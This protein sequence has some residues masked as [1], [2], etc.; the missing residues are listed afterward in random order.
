MIEK[1]RADRSALS[2]EQIN[3]LCAEFLSVRHH[4]FDYMNELRKAGFNAFAPFED[5]VL[6]YAKSDEEVALHNRVIV[7]E[8]KMLLIGLPWR[9]VRL[10][11]TGPFYSE[12][13]ENLKARRDEEN[14]VP[15]RE[16]ESRYPGDR[17]VWRLEFEPCRR[18]MAY[19][20]ATNP[21]AFE[22]QWKAV[23][24][25]G[26][27]RV[28]EE[29]T[30]FA[31]RLSEAYDFTSGGRHGLFVAVMEQEAKNLGFFYD[32]ERS[33]PT[34]PIFSNS[35]TP[36]W[37]LCL[38][39]EDFLTFVLKPFVGHID[40][41]LEIR[42][43]ELPGGSRKGKAEEYLRIR[44]S[45]VVPGFFHAYWTFHNLAELE[46]LIKA[47]LFLY[48]LMAPIIEGGMKKILGDQ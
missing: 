47:H 34:C 25:A 32:K 36:N 12:F 23:V 9:L 27:L 22:A 13:I 39:I 38:A 16:L 6:S 28:A 19:F 5:F 21:E 14:G 20:E 3:G 44:F 48:R 30:R 2:I 18:H 35:V 40:F 43:R 45:R 26:R 4:I 41:C 24:E 11:R 7:E 15:Q 46:T 8:P 17:T 42:P 10:T 29:A 33:S 37:D 31:T 1:E